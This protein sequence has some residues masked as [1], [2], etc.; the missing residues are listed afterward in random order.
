MDAKNPS[1]PLALTRH[2][3]TKSK[4]E[5]AAYQEQVRSFKRR[6]KKKGGAFSNRPT[7]LGGGWKI[8]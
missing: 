5:R 7:W 6:K 8:S 1:P 4:E 3:P 2:P